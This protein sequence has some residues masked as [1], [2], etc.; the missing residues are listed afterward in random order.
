MAGTLSGFIC[1]LLR[2]QLPLVCAYIFVRIRNVNSDT[3]CIYRLVSWSEGVNYLD[4]QPLNETPLTDS[5]MDSSM[6]KFLRCADTLLCSQ[7]RLFII[8][9][10]KWMHFVCVWLLEL[11]CVVTLRTLQCYW[12]GATLHYTACMEGLQMKSLIISWA[13]QSSVNLCKGRHVKVFFSLDARLTSS[14]TVS[15]N[16]N[17]ARRQGHP[18]QRSVCHY[19][20]NLNY[21]FQ[22]SASCNDL[23]GVK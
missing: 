3:L 13:I 12:K 15:L 21:T 4:E 5:F 14:L 10:T 18:R 16:V 11:V 7:P 19:K 22:H 9:V 20:D 8:C 6:W 23:Q 17:I 2:V 1:F